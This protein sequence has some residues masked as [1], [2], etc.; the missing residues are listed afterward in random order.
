MDW[1][2]KRNKT[3]SKNSRQQYLEE[4]EKEYISRLEQDQEFEFLQVL[5]LFF[6]LLLLCII[7]MKNDSIVF[8][9]EI[10]CKCMEALREFCNEKYASK[11]FHCN[12]CIIKHKICDVCLI[13]NKKKLHIR[14]VG[15]KGIYDSNLKKWK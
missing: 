2:F 5:D 10:F 13:K 7:R 14:I 3:S 15:R 12:H 8:Q 4:Y 6:F 11:S 9:L 1:K